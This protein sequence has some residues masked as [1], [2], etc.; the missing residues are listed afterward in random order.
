MVPEVHIYSIVMCKVEQ[1][2]SR[3][4]IATAKCVENSCFVLLFNCFIEQ[5]LA[6]SNCTHE[7]RMSCV[8]MHV[9][10]VNSGSPS[11]SDRLNEKQQ[12]LYF[13]SH[14]LTYPFFTF[15]FYF[16][17]PLSQICTS[18]DIAHWIFILRRIIRC[19]VEYKQGEGNKPARYTIS[20][21]K[22]QTGTTVVANAYGI[23]IFDVFCYR[24]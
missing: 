22:K 3:L 14:L 7:P 23:F 21:H 1:W 5:L 12:T 8:T 4:G 16:L 24:R 20:L 10:N 19:Y 9:I 13:F 2:W 15:P 11:K 17:L 18:G 6:I